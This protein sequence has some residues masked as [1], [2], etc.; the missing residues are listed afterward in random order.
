MGLKDRWG[1][2]V[3]VVIV[4]GSS[5]WP[6]EWVRD[7]AQSLTGARPYEG[8]WIF[9]PHLLFY[10]TLTAALAAICWTILTRMN[11]MPHPGLGV[12]RP[13]VDWAIVGG[14]V[15]VLA[16]LLFLWTAGLGHLGWVGFDGWKIAGNLFSNFYEE[17]IYRGFLLAALTALVRFWPAAVLSSMAFALGHDQY[18][19]SLQAFIAVVSMGWCWMVRR[20]GSIWSAWGAHM[21]MDIMIDAIWG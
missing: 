15:G 18:P 6:S 20:T 4:Y 11:L 13:A 9:V 17:F 21:V 19:L 7:A 16:S 2:A 1:L 10:C 5:F 3:G 8:I 12:S 14:L